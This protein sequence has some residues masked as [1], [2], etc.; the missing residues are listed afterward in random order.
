MYDAFHYKEMFWVFFEIMDASFG[1]VLYLRK[2]TLPEHIIKYILW[3]TLKGIQQLHK[4]HVI[5][6]DIKSDNILFN[7]KGEIKICDFG[8]ATQLTDTK[9]SR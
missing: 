9:K 3:R 4:R 6:R 2:E 7:A 8:F 1:N 5:H